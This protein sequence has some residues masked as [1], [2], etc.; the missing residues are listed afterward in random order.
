MLHPEV[1]GQMYSATAAGYKLPPHE[2]TLMARWLYMLAGGLVVAG[3]WMVW[4]SARK[5][6]AEAARKYLATCGGALAAGMCLALVGLAYWVVSLQPDAVRQGLAEGRLYPIAQIAWFAAIV[7]IFGLGVWNC[8]GKPLSNLA[9]GLAA[10]AALVLV[11]GMTV[12]RDGIRDLT[13]TARGFN[14]Q[15]ADL[16]QRA[17]HVNWPVVILFLLSLVASLGVMGW[18]ISVVVRAKPVEEKVNP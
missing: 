12:Y 13:L 8:L 9:G 7:M 15:G 11:G 18:L 5:N 3:L 17:V 16:W 1:W 4:L 6:I 14:I 2:P 10:L